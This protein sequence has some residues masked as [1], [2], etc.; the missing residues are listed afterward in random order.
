M[1]RG[2]FGDRV[3]LV[4]E[5]L[6]YSFA[7]LGRIP[8]EMTTD[9][10]KNV[11]PNEIRRV[12]FFAAS[13]KQRQPSSSEQRNRDGPV[14]ILKL[15]QQHSLLSSMFLTLQLLALSIAGPSGRLLP[16]LYGENG[17]V[18]LRPPAET[19]AQQPY[20]GHD[21]LRANTIIRCADAIHRCRKA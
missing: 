10:P 21:G 4:R 15:R 13:C 3:F 14:R 2:L 6:R 5:R 12:R 11:Y 18:R 17:A 7:R 9:S 1:E 19:S 16:D 8:L 20:D